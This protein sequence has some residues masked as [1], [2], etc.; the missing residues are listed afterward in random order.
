M[1]RT[2]A[3]GDRLLFD[4]T[5]MR[6]FD[7]ADSLRMVGGLANR[8]HVASGDPQEVFADAEGPSSGARILSFCLGVAAIAGAV[9][10]Q[11]ALV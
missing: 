3:A 2:I 10:L 5:L 11:L 7:A 9:A 6:A 1:L 4:G 8:T